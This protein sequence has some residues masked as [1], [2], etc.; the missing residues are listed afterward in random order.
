MHEPKVVNLI[1]FSAN[2]SIKRLHKSK[3]KHEDTYTHTLD[4]YTCERASAG[5][6]NYAVKRECVSTQNK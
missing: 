1:K 4:Y 3:V 5:L 6:N 2:S